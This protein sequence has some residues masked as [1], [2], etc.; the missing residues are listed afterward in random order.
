M[1]D[2]VLDLETNQGDRVNLSQDPYL[3]HINDHIE[4]TRSVLAG[5]DGHRPLP[6]SYFAPYAYWT[7]VEKAAFF[8]ALSIHSRLRPDLIAEEV[9]TKTV[10]DVC[11]YLDMLE[12]G[13]RTT[14]PM[15][16][17]DFPAAI[18]VSDKWIEFEEQKALS[19][20]EAEPQ[21]D[22]MLLEHAHEEEVRLKKASLRA[23]PET[24]PHATGPRDWR[25][26]VEKR[27]KFRSWLRERKEEWE[28]EDGLRELDTRTLK[29]V[30][31]VLKYHEE[32][33]EHPENAGGMEAARNEREMSPVEP[34]AQEVHG[35]DEF[36]GY[37]A[38]SDAGPSDGSTERGDDD[39]VVPGQGIST[40]VSNPS[41]DRQA[42]GGGPN[43][44]I[45]EE[46]LDP[47]LRVISRPG[48][49]PTVATSSG[50]TNGGHESVVASSQPLS[51][52][53]LTEPYSQFQPSTPPFQP[54][55]LPATTLQSV[56]AL[57]D[58]DNE[59][60]TSSPSLQ[61]E[62]HR[63]ATRLYMRRKRAQAKGVPFDEMMQLL[64]AP[65]GPRRFQRKQDDSGLPHEHM[66]AKERRR[67]QKRL[68][69][70]KRRAE[71]KGLAAIMT[72]ERLK[73]GPVAIPKTS[74]NEGYLE[75]QNSMETAP[76]ERMQSREVDADQEASTSDRAFKPEGTQPVRQVVPDGVW[77]DSVARRRNRM[78]NEYYERGLDSEQIHD[79]GFALIDPGGLAKL[80]RLYSDLHEESSD[81]G[82]QISAEVIRLLHA[83]AIRFTTQLVHVI[84]VLRE[85]ARWAK[86][87]WRPEPV[88]AQI[89]T[90]D[91][92]YAM[93]LLG[94]HEPSLEAH[95]ENLLGWL[96]IDQNKG[97]DTEGDADDH[98]SESNG[99]P[100]KR[101]RHSAHESH[102]STAPGSEDAG[103]SDQSESDE[104]DGGENAT[105]A[106]AHGQAS[107]VEDQQ[108]DIDN[109]MEAAEFNQLPDLPV[110]RTI[111]SPV[112]RLAQSDAT[113]KNELLA[114]NIALSR[115]LWPVPPTVDAM[116]D[117][118]IADEMDDAAVLDEILD[119]ES[120][121]KRD[122]EADTIYEAKIWDELSSSSEVP[123]RPN[124]AVKPKSSQK[125]MNSNAE[126]DEDQGS[127]HK[128]QRRKTRIK[129]EAFIYN[130]D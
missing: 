74:P 98:S 96:E 79:E 95:F 99:P 71:K 38:Q 50:V 49:S 11:I 12:E 127:S 126:D 121:D 120:L 48:A 108:L 114:P 18:E 56:Q 8:H 109:D 104:E 103:S 10:A 65:V 77:Q 22:A 62:Q 97:E 13:A 19:I 111:F 90:A 33:E 36:V 61:K 14:A 29:L 119:D 76:T 2:S 40:P 110:Y 128:L 20:I 105:S 107:D 55:P 85:R 52:L 93:A 118:L 59:I 43:S 42:V 44:H 63:L 75:A 47:V 94:C 100:R 64:E 123:T 9:K 34:S 41:A 7:S 28:A 115:G 57:A 39:A 1:A 129:S 23:Q 66:D 122:R 31:Q 54:I 125:R 51:S 84:L 4:H 26:R 24:S 68:Y 17:R 16:R 53:P 6:P 116:E 70:R 25:A 5:N 101:M 112:V 46:W 69:M 106:G 91:V 21:I 82:S 35:T 80:M 87:I 117:D 88:G 73:K 3:A 58:E 81:I 60:S 72:A 89:T 113:T 67:L 102:T 45:D 83:H 78:L 15:S 92:A 37:A 86:R 27:K 32:Q 124:A 30:A 130:S